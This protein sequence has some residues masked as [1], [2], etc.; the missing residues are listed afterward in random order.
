MFVTSRRFCQS[1]ART[2]SYRQTDGRM[3]GWTD[4]H[5][6]RQMTDDKQ[7]DRQRTYGRIDRL[8]M[9]G[10]AGRQGRDGQTDKHTDCLLATNTIAY[11]LNV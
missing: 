10:Q 4:K 11:K 2:Y 7:A 5:I 8:I 6:G 1:K 3:D 9:D